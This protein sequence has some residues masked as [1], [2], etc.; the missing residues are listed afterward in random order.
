MLSGLGLARV[1]GFPICILMHWFVGLFA[2]PHASMMP[3]VREGVKKHD[4]LI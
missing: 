3:H 4:Y 2:S 1:H